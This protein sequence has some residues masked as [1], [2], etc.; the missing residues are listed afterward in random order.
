[1]P[2]LCFL[3]GHWLGDQHIFSALLCVPLI[4][5]I[6][7]FCVSSGQPIYLPSWSLFSALL[8]CYPIHKDGL[9][10][11][12]SCVV[13]G[14]RSQRLFL[15]KSKRARGSWTVSPSGPALRITNPFPPS[16]HIYPDSCAPSPKSRP[17][18]STLNT[19][20]WGRSRFQLVECVKTRPHHSAP[21]TCFMR[22]CMGAFFPSCHYP[23][24]G[25]YFQ[26]LTSIFGLW[27]ALSLQFVVW[28]WTWCI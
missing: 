14:R 27:T 22:L 3:L 7:F 28:P 5:W 11:G 17:W 12:P 20:A 4:L 1:M 15:T 26:L 8:T 24:L 2:F 16:A 23:Q 13:Q 21:V 9:A 6:L 10:R 19:A 18:S 25:F